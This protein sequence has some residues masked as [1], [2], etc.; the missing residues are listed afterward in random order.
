[1][2]EHGSGIQRI[3]YVLIRLSHRLPGLAPSK[4]RG[5]CDCPFCSCGERRARA[6]AGMP[7]KH[8]ERILRYLPD[9]Q[10]KLL[11]GLAEKTWPKCEYMDII[12]GH[13][14]EQ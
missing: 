8:P 12:A 10:E 13:P 7:M 4:A 6:R 14:G 2:N 9:D 3:R 11:T 5:R 1:M